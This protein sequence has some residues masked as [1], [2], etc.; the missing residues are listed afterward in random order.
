M[1]AAGMSK[2]GNCGRA[3]MS[4]GEAGRV[5]EGA[6]APFPGLRVSVWWGALAGLA[7]QAQRA[8]TLH[9]VCH[10]SRGY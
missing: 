5:T 8:V 7:G 3:G 6:R 10:G 1:R 9:R 4:H 2:D